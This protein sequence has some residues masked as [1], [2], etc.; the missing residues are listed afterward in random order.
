MERQTHIV[1]AVAEV[2]SISRSDAH[3]LFTLGADGDHIRRA[4][5]TAPDRAPSPTTDVLGTTHAADDKR[6]QNH[7]P[8]QSQRQTATPARP[9]P[10]HDE[11]EN[12]TRVEELPPR[13]PDHRFQR[14]ALATPAGWRHGSHV[15]L[16][17]T[18]LRGAEYLISSVA[19]GLEDYYMGAGEAPGVWRGNWAEDLGLDGVVGADELRALVNGHDPKSGA[20]LLA[21]HRERKVRVVDVTLSCPK[22]VSLLWA[23]GTPETSAVV[24][25]AVVEATDTALKFL[26]ERAAF[27]RHQQGGV[28]RRVGTDGFAIATFAHRTQPG[29]RPATP[30]PLPDPQRRAPSGWRVCGVRRQ[31]VPC[32]GQSLGD[33]LLERS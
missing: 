28:R 33:R 11:A 7:R 13:P 10:R 4:A 12:P 26:E 24:S 16:T 1:N 27:A 29:R 22:S 8:T 14:Q 30:H 23:L 15:V 3:A 5:D 6:S 19:E 17:I 25:I 20:D 9:K 32:L 21:G 18:K 2:L 31:P